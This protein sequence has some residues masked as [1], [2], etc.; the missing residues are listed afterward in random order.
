[1]IGSTIAP[2]SVARDSSAQSRQSSTSS[3]TAIAATLQF[4]ILHEQDLMSSAS[5]FIALDPNASS[6]QF[7]PVGNSSV[8][9]VGRYRELLGFG[10][11]VIVTAAQLP[12]GVFVAGRRWTCS[13]SKT[14]SGGCG[15]PCTGRSA[16]EPGSYWWPRSS[17]WSSSSRCRT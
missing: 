2:G 7:L 3:S 17:P 4:A 11:S 13:G 15:A 6:Q 8:D 14:F 12:A 16:G 5:G 9:A 10:Y 1:V